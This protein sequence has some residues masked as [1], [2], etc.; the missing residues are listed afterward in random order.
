VTVSSFD[1][2]VHAFTAA[3]KHASDNDRIVVFGSFSTV[4]PVLS[5]LGRKVA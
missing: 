1:N 3:R 4:G 2:P 5:E